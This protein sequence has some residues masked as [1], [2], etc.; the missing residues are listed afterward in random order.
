MKNIRKKIA[1]LVLAG[2]MS[3]SCTACNSDSKESDNKTETT[4]VAVADNNNVNDNGGDESA[5]PVQENG[6]TPTMTFKDYSNKKAENG[7]SATWIWIDSG[8][9]DIAGDSDIFELTFKVKDGAADGNYEVV[10]NDLQICNKATQIINA[11]VA[12]AVV[13]IGGAQAPEQ[14][15]A[16]GTAITLMNAKGNAGDEIKMKVNFSKN[17]GFCA[18]QLGVSYDSSV[19][20]M[21]NV[22]NTGVLA[23]IGSV[24][25]NLNQ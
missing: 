2:I 1:V 11:T 24:T 18:I 21:T 6:N 19:L 15:T 14:A 23:D 22:V 10:V 17:P 5:P 3:L 20:E 7:K 9:E 8:I 25:Y 4:T 13:T 16:E 12:D